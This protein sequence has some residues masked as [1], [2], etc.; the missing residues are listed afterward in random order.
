MKKKEKFLTGSLLSLVGILELVLPTWTV[1]YSGSIRAYTPLGMIFNASSLPGS[2]TIFSQLSGYFAFMT[3]V[4]VIMNFVLMNKD[5]GLNINSKYSGGFALVCISALYM[6]L[7][8]IAC[9]G[10]E[11]AFPCGVIW[12]AMILIIFIVQIKYSKSTNEQVNSSTINGQ[13]KLVSKPTSSQNETAYKPIDSNSSQSTNQTEPKQQSA[14]STTIAND[15]D[16]KEC[17]ENQQNKPKVINPLNTSF[18]KK[19]KE[20]YN[21]DFDTFKKELRF[22]SYSN[23]A[24]NELIKK[25]SRLRTAFSVAY[26]SKFIVIIEDKLC[27]GGRMEFTEEFCSKRIAKLFKIRNHNDAEYI[28]LLELYGD[29]LFDSVTK[30]IYPMD[31]IK[32]FEY[33]DNKI[34]FQS[35]TNFGLKKSRL[36]VAL[37]EALFGTASAIVSNESSMSTETF[38]RSGFRLVREFNSKIPEIYFDKFDFDNSAEIRDLINLKS[39]ESYRVKAN[40]DS[41]NNSNNYVSPADEIRKYKALLDDGI[42]TQEE[43]DAKKKELLGI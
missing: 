30:L 40:S 42:I 23:R 7:G 13:T 17:I 19:F 21:V 22:L 1:D 35:N 15:K 18:Y 38:D 20:K 37:D 34:T 5:E 3:I 25:Y 32:Y 14:T 11:S 6:L 36:G 10:Y 33:V 8:F 41:V 16:E 26:S 2:L 39:I 31:D 27:V 4:A 12:F 9:I 24:Y 29:V 43:F 28:E